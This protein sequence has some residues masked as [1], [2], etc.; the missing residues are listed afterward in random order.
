LGVLQ[1]LPF[2]LFLHIPPQLGEIECPEAAEF[3]RS[4]YLPARCLSLDIALFQSED[5]YRHFNRNTLRLTRGN[6]CCRFRRMSH[7]L[8]SFI[9]VLSVAVAYTPLMTK[10]RRARKGRKWSFGKIEAELSAAIRYNFFLS[11]PSRR[12]TAGVILARPT[13]QVAAQ[14]AQAVRVVA[15]QV[16]IARR[17]NRIDAVIGAEK[18]AS[19]FETHFICECCCWSSRA[20]AIPANGHSVSMTGA[21]T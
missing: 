1:T 12:R 19:V 18:T 8:T 20:A 10:I 4:R 2:F 7:L 9:L 17:I 3:H 14:L 5:R 15:D 16:E 13:M 11:R 6:D 21:I